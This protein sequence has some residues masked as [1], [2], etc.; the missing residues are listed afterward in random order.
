MI[1]TVTTTTTAI[2]NTATATSLALIAILSLI[3]LLIQKEMI[4]GLNGER[5]KRLSRTLNVAIVPL[6]MVFMATVA[7]KIADILQ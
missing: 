3:T 6:A 2:L 5:A 4:S 1:T 7:F